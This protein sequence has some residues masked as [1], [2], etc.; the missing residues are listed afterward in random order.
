MGE[1]EAGIRFIV[2][3]FEGHGDIVGGLMS[4]RCILAYKQTKLQSEPTYDVPSCNLCDHPTNF[5]ILRQNTP[6]NEE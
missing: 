1:H 5:I 6:Y 3:Y 2:V 4:R